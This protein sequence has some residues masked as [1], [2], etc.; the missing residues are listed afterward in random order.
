MV[1][2]VKWETR[3][4]QHVLGGASCVVLRIEWLGDLGFAW[5]PMKQGL[6]QNSEIFFGFVGR[7]KPKLGFFSWTQPLSVELEV[8]LT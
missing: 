6:T 3:I 2:A 7:E 5:F 1:S 4:K 8:R